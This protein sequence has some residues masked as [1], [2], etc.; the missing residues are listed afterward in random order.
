MSLHRKLLPRHM[1][2]I[3]KERILTAL[4]PAVR[5]TNEKRNNDFTGI[6][7]DTDLLNDLRLGSLD[8]ALISEK[9]E[10]NLNGTYALSHHRGGIIISDNLS[11]I[12]KQRQEKI[13]TPLTIK[14]A[15]DIIAKEL[16]PTERI[17]A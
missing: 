1:Y 7:D 14:E 2:K 11:E 5:D 16:N 3:S 6:T 9:T 17:P 8:I 10:D 12:W 15:V 13:N 4:I